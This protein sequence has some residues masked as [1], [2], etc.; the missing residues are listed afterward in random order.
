M[1]ETPQDRPT[2]LRKAVEAFHGRVHQFFFAFGEFDGISIV[3]FD[4]SPVESSSTDD[5][6]LRGAL[7]TPDDQLQLHAPSEP[8]IWLQATPAKPS[9]D[10]GGD[11]GPEG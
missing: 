8:G 6:R 11:D 1:V 5:S 7:P 4:N 3:E 2:E 9:G 10:G